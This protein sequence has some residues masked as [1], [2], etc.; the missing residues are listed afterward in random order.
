MVVREGVSYPAARVRALQFVPMFRA[1]GDEVR[2]LPWRAH[3]RRAVALDSARL[4][5][6]ARWSD[7]VLLQRPNQPTRLLRSLAKLN[8]AVVVDFDDAL[9]VGAGGAESGDFGQRLRTAVGLARFVIAGSGHLAQWAQS[10]GGAR[11]VEVIRPAVDVSRT[12][13][14]RH[15]IERCVIG[16]IGTPGN[17]GD[18]DPTLLDVLECLTSRPTGG[19]RSFRI[20][21]SR[22]LPRAGLAA[23][24]VP[25]S[26][27]SER[28]AIADLDIGLM[29]L[30]RDDRSLGRCGYKTIQY[31]AAGVPAIVSP[32]GAGM[33]VVEDQVTGLWAKDAE[34]WADAIERL[35][36][37]PHERS[38]MGVAGRAWVE[39]HASSEV[40]FR[41]LR[42]ALTAA[43]V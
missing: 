10:V 32:W 9:W 36:R 1:H 20:I 15:G 4:L 33:E 12:P 40:A 34:E 26:M 17:L 5:R 29:P 18:L 30:G 38:Q 24:F 11:P 7:V 2:V 27:D 21:S 42:A 16:W 19:H 41:R 37:S 14:H 13:I 6:L 43:T 39:E 25:W 22:P 8:P 31:L 28:E 3:S 35:A 23:D